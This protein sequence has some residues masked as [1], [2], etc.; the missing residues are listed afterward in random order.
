MLRHRESLL[1]L[2]VRDLGP[3]GEDELLVGVGVAAQAQPP[4]AASVRRTQVRVGEAGRR[5]LHNL[6]TPKH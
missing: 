4:G 1:G 2:E 3:G 5:Q 6:T